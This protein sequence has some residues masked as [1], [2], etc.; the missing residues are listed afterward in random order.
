MTS[1]RSA[2]TSNCKGESKGPNS[3]RL[4][5][6]SRGK[7]STDEKLDNIYVILS[8]LKEQNDVL[9]Q[10]V[11][12]LEQHLVESEDRQ[13]EQDNKLNDLEQYGR[14]NTIRIV[15][16]EDSNRNETDEEC[17]EKIV[18][19]VYDKLNVT[20]VEADIDIAHR[21]GVYQR[22]KP[23][24]IICKFTH[25][26]RKFKIIKQRKLLKG[27]RC[28]I[29]E[30]LTRINQQRLKEAFELRCVEISWSTDGKLFVLLKNGEKRRIQ[31]NAIMTEAF[32]MNDDNFCRK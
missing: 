32:L 25:R 13:C 16:L 3:G 10:T 12:K 15:G 24:N 31:Y 2:S 7:M 27:T 9:K 28:F 18:K 4:R 20:I 19:F 1:T 8:T 21:L 22:G 6:I 17:V 23:R 30:D 14:K 29:M 11:S 5:D 26:I